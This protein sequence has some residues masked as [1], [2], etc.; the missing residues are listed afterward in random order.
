MNIKKSFFQM[1]TNV[2]KG[3]VAV[4][5]AFGFTLFTGCE[6]AAN[7]NATTASATTSTSN[8]S[9]KTEDAH[10]HSHD[11]GDEGEHGGHLVHLEPGGA[12]AEWSHDDEKGT[13]TVFMEE[14]VSG[15]AKV[16]SVRVDLEVTGNPKKA[17]AFEKGADEH[18]IENSVFTIKSPELVTALGV[19]EGVKATLVVVMDGKEHSCKLEH[20]HGHDH[21]H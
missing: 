18:K 12:H 13:V 19:G 7:Q 20:D 5:A 16:E 3:I 4:V 21:D 10:N 6:P 14:A 2:S 9:K 8:T 17:Y 11:H 1:G 15:G